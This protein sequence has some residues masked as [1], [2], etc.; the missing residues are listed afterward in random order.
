MELSSPLSMVNRLHT[1]C[2]LTQSQNYAPAR[3]RVLVCEGPDG[4]VEIEY[5]GH[6]V[7]WREIAGPLRA[8]R[9][10]ARPGAKGAAVPTVPIPK[11]KWV[12]PPDHPWRQ[13]ARYGAERRANL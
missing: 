2:R 11:R 12:P 1:N 9:P 6:T 8:S 7:P 4:R 5:R 3:G 10:E 13:V